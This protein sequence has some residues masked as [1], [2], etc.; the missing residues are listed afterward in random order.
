[1]PNGYPILAT[2]QGCGWLPVP[3]QRLPLPSSRRFNGGVECQQ[4]GLIGDAANGLDNA[5]DDTGQFAHR[6]DADG[7]FVEILGNL[8]DANTSLSPIGLTL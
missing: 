7:G 2:I 1:M 4:I 6:I 8:F 3:R 5:A